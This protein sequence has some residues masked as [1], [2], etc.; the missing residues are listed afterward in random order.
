MDLINSFFYY[1]RSSYSE[2][3]TALYTYESQIH[4]IAETKIN[5]LKK[6]YG[7]TKP[8]ALE[9][10]EVHKKADVWHREQCKKLISKID[11]NEQSLALRAS[12]SVAQKL[13][14]FL[15]SMLEKHSLN[16]SC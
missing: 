4:E 12:E 6:F 13:W 7:I 9:F 2:G 15:S 5:G 1:C 11:I 10:F 14:N 8:E 3:L 16:V